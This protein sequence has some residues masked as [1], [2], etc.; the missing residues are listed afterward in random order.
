MHKKI[1]GQII[2]VIKINYLSLGIPQQIFLF[3]NSTGLFR[4]INQE[5]DRFSITVENWG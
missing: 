1:L 4:F 3:P 2:I 5:N